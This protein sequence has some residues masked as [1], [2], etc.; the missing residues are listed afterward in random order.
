MVRRKRRKNKNTKIIAIIFVLLTIFVS[1]YFF[2]PEII[3]LFNPSGQKTQSY[4]KFK[5]ELKDYSVFGIDVSQYQ[6]DI[7]WD[8]LFKNH[9]IDFV[10]IRATMGNNKTD[11][12][13][14]KN[15][16]ALRS[17]D[18]VK[19]A[20]HY[21][22]P[23]ENSTLQAM[24]YIKNVKL[25]VGDLP[26]VL[27]IE[28]YSRVQSVNSLK[29]GLLNWLTLVEKHYGTTPILYTY[30]K[31]YVSTIQTDRRFDKYPVWIAWYNIKGDPNTIFNDWVFWQFTEKGLFDGIEGNVDIN[32][33]NGKK[34]DLDGLRIK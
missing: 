27:D 7:D 32:V 20:Y 5:K 25:E 17:S 28:K 16:N 21:Y 31:F 30:N 13:F 3:S 4:D 1:A 23:D 24:N 11:S 15:W 10:I 9:Q 6:A 18:V 19:G 29:S 2:Y 12:K 22:R 33:F 34:Q 26:P 8:K 14:T